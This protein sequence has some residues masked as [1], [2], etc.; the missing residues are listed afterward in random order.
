MADTQNQVEQKYNIWIASLKRF[1]RTFIPQAI[2]FLPLLV[3]NAEKIQQVLPLW[4]IP[5]L[6]FLA[7]LA[8]AFD[9]LFRSLKWY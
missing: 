8:T 3:E 6:M 7:S 5:A 2:V 1:L 4:V 9:K